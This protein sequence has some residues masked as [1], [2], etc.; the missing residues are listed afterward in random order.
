[1]PR[2]RDSR[3]RELFNNLKT[4][5]KI[6]YYYYNVSVSEI[7]IKRH[8][9]IPHSSRKKKSQFQKKNIIIFGQM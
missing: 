5:R 6:A 4:K 1:M 8:R 9:S 7:S 2:N 3:S